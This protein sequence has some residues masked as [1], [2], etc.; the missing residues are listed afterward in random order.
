MLTVHC[1]AWEQ[2][3]GWLDQQ[4]SASDNDPAA[5]CLP[6]LSSLPLDLSVPNFNSFSTSH[7]PTLLGNHWLSDD[8]TSTG[9]E[10]ISS[11]PNCNPSL[12]LLNSFFLNTLVLN[13]QHPN[14][15]TSM[16]G[17]ASL[18]KNLLSNRHITQLLIPVHHLSHWTALLVDIPAQTY[19]YFDSLCPKM[20]DAPAVC[21]GL[22]NGWLTEV[23]Q[24]NLQLSPVMSCYSND[25]QINSHSC[26]VAVM[27]LMAHIALGLIFSWR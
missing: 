23:L 21:I 10:Y 16:S 9:V 17:P 7:F 8:H 26:S 5:K 4:V 6:K 13:Q 14:G 24:L 11:H 20:Y 18:L 15:R 25:Q 1:C 2:S 19:T 27:S 22:L 3:I 12:R